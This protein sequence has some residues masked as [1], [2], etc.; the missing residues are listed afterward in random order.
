MSAHT[1]WDVNR[2]VYATKDAQLSEKG[3]VVYSTSDG[4]KRIGP[5]YAYF[6]RRK[7]RDRGPW[8]LFAYDLDR[9]PAP[10]S[11]GQLDD[12]GDNRK[13]MG[14]WVRL[15]DAMQRVRAEQR[16]RWREFEEMRAR[17]DKAALLRSTLPGYVDRIL[18]GL[19]D[20]EDPPSMRTIIALDMAQN[21]LDKLQQLA[22]AFDSAVK[23]RARRMRASVLGHDFEGADS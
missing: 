1:I 14:P 19:E 11:S 20:V 6:I 16:R 5:H 21:A 10:K 18:A 4:N 17:V 13:E 22:E 3:A 23:D 8:V 12:W 2:E 7:N 9:G 15:D